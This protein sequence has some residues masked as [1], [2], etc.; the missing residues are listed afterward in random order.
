MRWIWDRTTKRSHSSSSTVR[1]CKS[2]NLQKKSWF[3]VAAA[4]SLL[5][6]LVTMTLIVALVSLA[7]PCWGVITRSRSQQ[8]A[9]SLVMS[10]LERARVAAIAQKCNLWVVFQHR[11]P[12]KQDSFR[13]L[14]KQ[15]LI[16]TPLGAWQCLPA[17]I[18]FHPGAGSLMQAPPPTEVVASSF[19][20][21]N[22]PEGA[23]FGVLMFLGSGRVGMPLPGGPPLLLR[24]DSISKSTP[25]EILIS[26]ATGRATTE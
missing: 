22:A 17:G 4:F 21:L 11:Q 18:S 7:V 26:R 10:S 3:G 13:L 14:S 23:S 12:P 24:L 19:N 15:G 8:A 1:F 16:M 9:T 25:T 5:E 20:G 2:L 6:I